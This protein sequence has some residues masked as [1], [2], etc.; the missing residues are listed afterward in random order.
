MSAC[1]MA[2]DAYELSIKSVF[3]S[4]FPKPIQRKVAVFDLSREGGIWGQ[5]VSDA[6][7][8]ETVWPKL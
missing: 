2:D 6:G 8:S 5:S 1:G 7:D 3:G 4:V